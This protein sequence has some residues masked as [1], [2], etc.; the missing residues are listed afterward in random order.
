MCSSSKHYEEFK[1]N[2]IDFSPSIDTKPTLCSFKKIIKIVKL[3]HMNWKVFFF[4]FRSWQ[5]FHRGIWATGWCYLLEPLDDSENLLSTVLVCF[6]I[7]SFT[8]STLT[9][10]PKYI[11][12]VSEWTCFSVLNIL[13]TSNPKL[14]FWTAKIGK[15]KY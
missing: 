13:N 4:V 9:E 12:R 8:H 6:I 1:W 7:F 15:G 3:T 2:L 14:L 11:Y 5:I 10:F